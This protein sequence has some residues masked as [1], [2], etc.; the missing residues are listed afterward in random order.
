MSY[1]TPRFL[2]NFLPLFLGATVLKLELFFKDGKVQRHSAPIIEHYKQ[3]FSPVLKFLM[4][5][6]REEE[7]FKIIHTNINNLN[8]WIIHEIDETM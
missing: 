6:I 2:N 3:T 4:K 8:D 7:P 5:N 1:V